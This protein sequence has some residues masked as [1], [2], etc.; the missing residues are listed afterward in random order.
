LPFASSASVTT[1]RRN[2]SGI[3]DSGSTSPSSDTFATAE[4]TSRSHSADPRCTSE[5]MRCTVLPDDTMSGENVS[6]AKRAMPRSVATHSTPSRSTCVASTTD[7]GRPSA[8]P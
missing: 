7:P 3:S 6:L 4:L 1:L 8:S 2:S 5:K